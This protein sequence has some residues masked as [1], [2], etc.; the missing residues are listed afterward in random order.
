M[1]TTQRGEP[2]RLLGRRRI[3]HLRRRSGRHHPRR[4]R[5]D[6][7]PEHPTP[8]PQNTGVVY[9]L[10]TRRSSTG[11][12]HDQR[13][14]HRPERHDQRDLRRGGVGRPGR[15]LRRRRR[16]R[17]RRPPGRQRRR[18]ADRCADGCLERGAAYLIYG[19]SAW[20]A[21][22]TTINGVR[23]INLANVGRPGPTPSRAPRSPAQPAAAQTGLA[24]S[25]GG[26]LQR[27]RLRR[28]PGWH[29]R[30]QQQLNG[31]QSGRGHPALRG[32]EHFE[33]GYLTG[34]I[35]LANIPTAIHRL[36]SP[37]RTPA[38]WPATPSRSSGSSTPASPL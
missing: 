6:G 22:A 36:V 26:R 34:T 7:R 32:S 20:R 37:A 24:V 27:R 11:S 21:C 33:R 35:S 12:Q 17:Q 4:S 38:T 14:D 1:N 29:A 28:H 31:D 5:R 19:G 3:E 8:G 25:S 18:P 16:R 2:A 10:S 15:L 9:A 23:Y 30:L 13:L